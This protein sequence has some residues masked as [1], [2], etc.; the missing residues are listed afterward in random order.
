[1][2]TTNLGRIDAMSDVTDGDREARMLENLRGLKALKGK[3]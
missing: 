3:A 1:M 2:L